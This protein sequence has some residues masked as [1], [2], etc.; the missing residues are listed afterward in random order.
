VASASNPLLQ[1]PEELSRQRSGPR[2]ARNPRRTLR[3]E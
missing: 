3:P 2:H 1:L